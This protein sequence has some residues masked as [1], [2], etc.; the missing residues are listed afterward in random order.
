MLIPSKLA[1][2]SEYVYRFT[3]TWSVLVPVP[4][5]ST[6]TLSF[7]AKV[8]EA[9]DSSVN[10]WSAIVS[11]AGSIVPNTMPSESPSEIPLI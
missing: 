10:V 8:C 6:S 9:G 11:V 3:S 2:G 5:H 1:A 7:A 4:S